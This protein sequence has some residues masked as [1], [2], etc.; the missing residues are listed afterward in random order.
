[1]F[2]CICSTV[3]FHRCLSFIRRKCSVSSVFVAGPCGKSERRH[4]ANFANTEVVKQEQQSFANRDDG[5]NS[6]CSLKIKSVP[7]SA[8]QI[9]TEVVRKN[10]YTCPD[11]SRH[12]TLARKRICRQHSLTSCSQKAEQAA[13]PQLKTD[14][15]PYNEECLSASPSAVPQVDPSDQISH[16]DT[17]SSTNINAQNEVSS[18]RLIV[19]NQQGS[20]M[21]KDS[22][23]CEAVPFRNILPEKTTGKN[24]SGKE[25]SLPTQNFSP[26]RKIQRKIRVYKRKR[27]KVNTHLEHLKQNDVPDESILRLWELFQYSDDMD[28]EFC[29]FED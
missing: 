29:G 28:V 19:T 23:L 21:N 4:V 9:H 5:S 25:E 7:G 15:A 22:L 10:C 1:M 2:L 16:K 24:L 17:N 13:I 18:Q 6:G 14:T 3:P 8:S 27:R 12:K 26:V 20:D 11:V